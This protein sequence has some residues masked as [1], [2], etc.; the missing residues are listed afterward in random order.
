MKYFKK[1]TIYI[2][3]TIGFAI[4]GS[5]QIA[6][7]DCATAI[8]FSSGVFD[9]D[10]ATNSGT[11][12]RCLASNA[13]DAWFTFTSTTD[14]RLIYSFVIL[15][16]GA[17]NYNVNPFYYTV[18]SGSCGNLTEFF[19][20]Y[21]SAGLHR[22][23][24][25]TPGQ[26]Y[27]LRISPL[28]DNAEFQLSLTS[29]NS[30]N[31]PAND[32]CIDSEDI[33]LTLAGTNVTG[34]P[35]D[36]FMSDAGFPSC[37]DQYFQY[38][39]W[40]NFTTT[41][42]GNVIIE[43]DAFPND[44]LW[45][46][47]V[48]SGNCGALNEVACGKVSGGFGTDYYDY[49]LLQL[50]PNQNYLL[51][52]W[53]E[54]GDAYDPIQFDIQAGLEVNNGACADRELLAV[55]AE[56]TSV[57]TTQVGFGGQPTEPL[58]SCDNF[59]SSPLFNPT[60][61]W[62]EFVAPAT[63]AVEIPVG[64]F[65]TKVIYSG[66]C[67]SLTEVGCKSGANGYFSGLT[68]GATYIL[69]ILSNN[70][71]SQAN[72]VDVCVISAAPAT[73]NDI[74]D[75]AI[76][77]SVST[78]CTSPIIGNFN[79]AT[80][81]GTTSP[82]C[83][84]SAADIWFSFSPT[85]TGAVFVET[86]ANITVQVFG[87]SCGTLTTLFSCTT[88][89]NVFSGLDPS[90][91]Y[92]LQLRGE[93]E[94]I[95]FC[96]IEATGPSNNLCYNAQN[97]TLTN[98]CNS[99]VADFDNTNRSTSP[100]TT[101]EGNR[102]DLY[103]DVTVPT[104]G[105]IRTGY[106]AHTGTTTSHTISLLSGTCDNAAVI[107]CVT[108][109]DGIIDI[110]GLS[111]GDELILRLATSLTAN[112]AEICLSKVADPP[113]NDLCV[114][115]TA[116]TL[117]G[118][119]CDQSLAGTT[120]GATN[121]QDICDLDKVDVFY[122]YTAM[123]TG[124]F[125]V[126]TSNYTYDLTVA[127]SASCAGPSLECGTNSLSMSLIAG[128]ARTII[129][130]AQNNFELTDFDICIKPFDASADG[131][132]VGIGVSTPI[133]KLQ[134]SG[135]ILIGNTD[136]SFPGS[137]RYDGQ[138]IEGFVDGQ[139][140]SMTTITG[141]DLG[142]HTATTTLDMA[143][144]KIANVSAPTSNTD[145]ANKSYV[146]A[147]RDGDFSSSNEIQTLSI[148]GNNLSIS[149][150]NTVTLPTGSV[151]WSEVNNIPSGFADGID[152][153]VDNDNDPTN[154]IETWATLGGKPSGF[155]DNVDNVNDSDADP[156][157]ELISSFDYSNNTL[158]ITE[159]PTNY[160]ADLNNLANYWSRNPTLDLLYSAGDITIGSSATPTDKLL[161]INGGIDVVSN[162]S[163]SNAQLDLTESSVS[164]GAR[165]NF[166]NAGTSNIWTI[167]GRAS[168]SSTAND[169][170][171]FHNVAGNVLS[172]EGETGD[173]GIGGS[174]TS[175]LHVFQGNNG[176]ADGI[177]LQNTNN[178]NAIRLY[179]SSSTGYLNFY[180]S[181]NGSSAIASINN[182]TG[183]YSAL[184]DRRMKADIQS[185]QLDWTKFM[186]LDPSTYTYRADPDGKMSIGMIAQDVKKLFPELVQYL[187]EEDL[188]HL[189]YS[190]FGIL[191]IT[192]IQE[193]QKE[194]ISLKA[195]IDAQEVRLKALEEKMK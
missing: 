39:M 194:I 44:N 123:E 158:K 116:L 43:E 68:P 169:F 105:I 78:D 150:S 101:C 131:G 155:A 146:D 73:T 184:S 110:S 61:V 137:M 70:W 138:D 41:P 114:N 190:G 182:A 65:Y 119:T 8:P 30:D 167:F 76:G 104:N 106:I 84:S 118:P 140:R 156:T 100:S 9:F 112:S 145:A 117:S 91:T 109:S 92:F 166:K 18:Y 172:L 1:I 48:F 115:A 45:E 52:I 139:W 160:V 77:I 124:N 193:Q 62:Y 46:Y 95:D 99:F 49:A 54:R 6:N 27:Y 165:I 51:R 191:A 67:G 97:V 42:S 47:Q 66:S 152:N 127:S 72:A 144:Q 15:Q 36:A 90:E 32:D 33:T 96:L 168:A 154:E 53:D 57:S 187:P 71:D 177:I 85:S 108:P 74:C 79:D 147:H 157:N 14:T 35:D 130:S 22:I 86:S 31:P 121:D 171:I 188:Y 186:Q 34:D 50:N 148:N 80:S 134:V 75:D 88:P 180:S 82:G 40:Y 69:R 3:C 7:D 174:P 136:T 122:T 28:S 159:G 63:G 102:H 149:S 5:S 56:C 13:N 132:N 81:S 23:V 19:C 58:P 135:G 37:N 179:T 10:G 163:G 170:N 153:V 143:D 25:L 195:Q 4:S 176:G 178:N 133:Q 113:A 24:G 60:E 20:S 93:D 87:G 11:A 103:Y 161:V 89:G 107:Q 2:I 164:D 181:L 125:T 185:L 29:S 175:D 26:Q 189:D 128:E 142:D 111:A 183:A 17:T 129:V 21:R 12:S 98:S 83:G 64:S 16:N 141:D 173:V 55:Q 162:S 126:E 38:D 94:P 151:Q 120:F 192:A 59:N